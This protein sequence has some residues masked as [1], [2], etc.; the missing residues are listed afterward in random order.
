MKAVRC[1]DNAT[2]GPFVFDFRGRLILRNRLE[3]PLRYEAIVGV[4]HGPEPSAA[5][6]EAFREVVPLSD[7][8]QFEVE[9]SV[10]SP[11][12]LGGW[13]H[14]DA[15]VAPC[16]V[17]PL[18][19]AGCRELD[20]GEGLVGPAWKTLVPMHSVLYRPMIDSIRALS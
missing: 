4:I 2:A 11:F 15:G 18:D 13:H 7:G 6:S 9:R 16:V 10:V 5:S 8:P 19:P 14:P 3:E 1:C 20:V 12:E 17:V